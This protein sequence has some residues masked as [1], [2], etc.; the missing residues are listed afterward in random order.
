MR[1]ASAG[2]RAGRRARDEP[3][4]AALGVLP[5]RDGDGPGRVLGHALP[6]GPE[7]PGPELD[8]RL[9]GR[10]GHAGSVGGHRGRR[11]RMGAGRPPDDARGR[12]D[13][14][15]R[16]AG[17]SATA[18]APPVDRSA[19]AGDRPIPRSRG[20]RRPGRA[21]RRTPRS[22]APRRVGGWPPA[23]SVLAELLRQ[24]RGHPDDEPG[25]EV[26]YPGAGAGRRAVAGARAGDAGPAGVHA[27]PA[28]AGGL[29]VRR[30]RRPAALPSRPVAGE[31]D[32]PGRDRHDGRRPGASPACPGT[33]DEL[34]DLG[35]AFNDL[36]D[37]L[38]E[39]FLRDARGARPAATVRRRCLASA[40]HPPDGLAR[41]GPGRAPARPLG[42]GLPPGP[43]A[44]PRRGG[45]PAA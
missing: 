41:P 45:P 3:G 26:Q 5:D 44:G 14:S 36:L 10:P 24:G 25:Y 20:S 19:N 39:A 34:D 6:A 2:P 1:S 12:A 43:G 28:V 31:P 16:C 13:R 42:G 38:H 7:L 18:G 29:G 37:R 33:G 32:G 23:G 17:R 11:A 9:L 15:A 35:R 40:P 4:H 27:D 8:E 21:I 30:D 22:S